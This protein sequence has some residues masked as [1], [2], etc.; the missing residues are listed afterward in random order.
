MTPPDRGPDS[1]TGKG[2]DGGDP[3]SPHAGVD[4]E[5]A[6]GGNDLS[7][8]LIRIRDVGSRIRIQA[9][10][11]RLAAIEIPQAMS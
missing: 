3:S 2:C 7:H 11:P 1:F 10:P 4:D 9:A 5:R 6:S 8:P